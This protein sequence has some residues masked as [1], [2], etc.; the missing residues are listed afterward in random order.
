VPPNEKMPGSKR[1]SEASNAPASI[2][3]V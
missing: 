3:A 1:H 2:F